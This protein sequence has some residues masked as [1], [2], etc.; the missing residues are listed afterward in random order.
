MP[1]ERSLTQRNL[2]PWLPALLALLVIA[3]LVALIGGVDLWPGGDDE[4]TTTTSTT[5]TSSTTTTVP[6]EP[7]EAAALMVEPVPATPAASYRV[8]YDLV[9]NDAPTLS[10]EVTV[11]RPY[12]SLD[13]TRDEAG[14]LT[15]GDA[16][17]LSQL[18]FYLADQQGWLPLQGERHRAEADVRPLSGLATMIELGLVTEQGTASYAGRDCTVYV[19]GAPVTQPVKAPAEDETTELCI[20]SAGIVLHE[21]WQQSGSVLLERTATSVEIEPPIDD[22]IFDPAEII[23]DAEKYEGQLASAAAAT[24]EELAALKTDIVVPEGY[25]ADGAVTRAGSAGSQTV[26]FYSDG[27][28]LIELV[29]TDGVPDADLALDGARPVEIEGYGQ[30]WFVPGFKAS[31]LRVRIGETGTAEIIG[32]YPAQ[33][34]EILQ[35]LTLR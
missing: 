24:E 9:Q 30:A 5:T 3:L 14:T 13:L 2:P 6:P 23:A 32:P 18:Y 26:R 25:M 19:T 33:L 31:T 12:E 21:R 4:A 15:T 1:Q 17:S 34:V 22:A 11:R 29:E 10:E 27:L 7:I 8:T 20:G 35:S 28:N 16:T